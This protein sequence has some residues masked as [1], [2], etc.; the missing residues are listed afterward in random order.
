MAAHQRYAL[1]SF[2]VLAYTWTWLCWWSVFAVSSGY[3]SLPVPQ[4]YLATLGQFGPFAAAV[5]VTYVT[6]SRAGFRE[7]LSRLGRWR[8]HPIWI[9]V[10]MLLL[11]AT[12]LMAIFLYAYFKGTVATLRFQDAWATLPAHFIYMLVLGGPLGEEPGWR[13]FALPRLQARYGAVAASVWLGLLW[14]GWHLPLWWIYPPPCPFLLYVAGAIFM[15][16]LFTWLFNHTRGSVLYSLIFHNSMSIAS[17]RLPEVPAYHV[18][19]LCLLSVVLVILFYDRQL[20]QSDDEPSSKMHI[21]SPTR[22]MP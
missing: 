11:P 7:F 19:V 17:V 3:L 15:T 22:Y 21:S 20:G 8:V 14:A 2:F 1:T 13:G 12:M 18:W 4:Q 6:S 16:F 9:L 5:F 10:S